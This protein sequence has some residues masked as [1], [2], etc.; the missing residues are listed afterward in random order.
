VVLHWAVMSHRERRARF[1]LVELRRSLEKYGYAI[2]TTSPE[3]WGD[4]W[5]HGRV[6]KVAEG[7]RSLKIRRRHPMDE[8]EKLLDQADQSTSLR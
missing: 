3:P 5:W 4:S 8:I 7:E 2:I 6:E 1:R